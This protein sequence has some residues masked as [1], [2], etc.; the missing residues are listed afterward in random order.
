MPARFDT[1]S[2]ADFRFDAD[3]V[4]SLY[5]DTARFWTRAGGPT[6]TSFSVAPNTLLRSALSTVRVLH[7]SWIVSGASSI[8]I[9]ETLADGNT[10]V[11]SQPV[12]DGRGSVQ[13]ARPNQSATFMLVATNAGGLV[14]RVIRTFRIQTG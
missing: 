9:H 8:E 4:D 2:P 11:N 3:Q 12:G 13:V 7:L 5:F 10:T 1:S 14:T 6:V